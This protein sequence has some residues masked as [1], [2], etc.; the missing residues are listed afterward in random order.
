MDTNKCVVVLFALVLLFSFLV[1]IH[2]AKADT[3]NGNGSYSVIG[4]QSPANETYNSR[5]LTLNVSFAF[6]LGMKYSLYYSINGKYIG[7]IPWNISNPNEVHVVYHASG[8]AKL[9]ELAEGSHSLTVTLV[10]SGF[11]KGENPRTYVNTVEFT[12]DPNANMKE[13]TPPKIS[14]ISIENKTYF[15]PDVPLV[16]TLNEKVSQVAY[17]LDGKDNI[18]VAGNNTLTGLP[19]G[20]H[21]L[22]VY[23]SDTAGNV[24]TQTVYFTITN[25]TTAPSQQPATMAALQNSAIFTAA[26]ASF[27]LCA[28][29]YI[30]KHKHKPSN[31]FS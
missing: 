5:F 4:I 6:G 10:A 30:K 22:T 11:V 29:A 25:K 19:T 12:T 8:S 28:L 15:T 17:S 9:P 21:S 1:S 16:F 2:S 7:F 20:A 14:D 31:L 18:T 13:S 3:A 26:A 24:D 23:A 27:G